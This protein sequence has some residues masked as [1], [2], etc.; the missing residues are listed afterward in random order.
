M[1]LK[2]FV[3]MKNLKIFEAG[4][5]NNTAGQVFIF[6]LFNTISVILSY[7]TPASQHETPGSNTRM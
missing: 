3:E 6:L 7:Q 1:L 5:V 4:V 2:L